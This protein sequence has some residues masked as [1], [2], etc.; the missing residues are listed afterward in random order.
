MFGRKGHRDRA[1]TVATPRVVVQPELTSVRVSTS[2]PKTPRALGRRDVEFSFERVFVPSLIVDHTELVL[3]Q[4]GQCGEEGFVVWAG[5]I[6][7]GNAYIC[8]LVMPKLELGKYDGEVSAETTAHLLEALDERDLVPLLQ[9]HSH[10]R[11]AF[12]SPID[13]IR[14]LVAVPGFMS[15]VLPHF[16]FIDLA[17]VA[18]WSAHRFLGAGG[19]HEL[20]EG[21]LAHQFIIDDSIIRVD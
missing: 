9:I 12:L 19:W 16:G 7:E 3:R 5:S 18:N 10:P 13:A 21:E 4:A 6:A 17:E 2:K 20:S 15:I 8:S 14:P 1:S 11:A